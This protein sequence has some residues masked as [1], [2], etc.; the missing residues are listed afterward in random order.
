M[1]SL[2]SVTLML[3]SSRSPL[4]EDPAFSLETKG[5]S[6]ISSE[7]LAS[8]PLQLFAIH[9]LS[10]DLLPSLTVCFVGSFKASKTSLTDFSIC[11]SVTEEGRSNDFNQ[12]SH[13]LAVAR[14]ALSTELDRHVKAVAPLQFWKM[15]RKKHHQ[16]G[17]L[18]YGSF[19]PRAIEEVLG[20]LVVSG[21]VL[22]PTLVPVAITDHRV[23]LDNTTSNGTFS[24]LDMLS[25]EHVKTNSLRLWAFFIA[26]YWISLVKYYMLWKAYKHI[27]DL[28]AMAL[29]SPVV[30]TEQFAVLVR[31]IPP[32]SDGETKKEQ[33][34]SYFQSI[35]LDKLIDPCWPLRI[36]RST[37][38]GKTWKDTE[39]NLQCNLLL[40]LCG[41]EV[42]RGLRARA[43]T[44]SSPNY[45]HLKKKLT[46]STREHLNLDEVGIVGEDTG[47]D[48]NCACLLDDPAETW[49]FK[50]H[51]EDSTAKHIC[52]LQKQ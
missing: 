22:L 9:M 40:D 41:S 4:P 30:K 36:K 3:P 48:D 52:A 31:D 13:L 19:M 44:T 24:D 15:I 10:V 33:I 50:A 11:L 45:L 37:E 29:V 34:D 26:V 32:I 28:R 7:F 16:F 35:Y 2:F 1:S 27:S 25:M 8:S 18:H 46:A 12:N 5:L 17:Q 14:R 51:G 39:R 23:K 42:F 21:I 47:W 20:I 43:T 38:Y 6:S 49:S